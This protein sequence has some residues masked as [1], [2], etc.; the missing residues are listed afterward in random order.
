MQCNCCG[1]KIDKASAGISVKIYRDIDNIPADIKDYC[2]YRWSADK[3]NL[4]YTGSFGIPTVCTECYN[5]FMN[6]LNKYIKETKGE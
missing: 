5:K 4:R 1:K 3:P 2:E 6:T